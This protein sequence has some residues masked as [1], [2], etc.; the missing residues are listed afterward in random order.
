M[1][2]NVQIPV[3]PSI[4]SKT[5]NGGTYHISIQGLMDLVRLLFRPWQ[6]YNPF[7]DRSFWL[8]QIPLKIPYQFH[9]LGLTGKDPQRSY[10]D[11]G[12][13]ILATLHRRS[14]VPL[15]F[16]FNNLLNEFGR[17]T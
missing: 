12:Q 17:V 5:Q 9:C 15:S 8:V 4:S 7:H 3:I 14:L 11:E 2:Y 10:S 13:E 1:L 16:D 6:P